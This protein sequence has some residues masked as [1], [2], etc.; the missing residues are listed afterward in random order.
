MAARVA[1]VLTALAVWTHG[2][3]ILPSGRRL[4]RSSS[5]STSKHSRGVVAMATAWQPNPPLI[6]AVKDYLQSGFP[7]DIQK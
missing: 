3:R 1:L 6:D 7:G 4:R 2:P 5:I